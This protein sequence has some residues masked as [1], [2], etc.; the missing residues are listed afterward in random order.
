MGYTQYIET[1]ID[2][3]CTSMDLQPSVLDS[4]ELDALH[5]APVTVS[6]PKS[7]AALSHDCAAINSH[8]DHDG[9]IPSKTVC[10]C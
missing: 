9:H 3:L 10:F 6:I 2:K 7:I 1:I 4:Q 8:F 5:D